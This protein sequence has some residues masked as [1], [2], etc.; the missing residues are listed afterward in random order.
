MMKLL[1]K[2]GNMIDT[3]HG[4]TM[5][6]NTDILIYDGKIQAIG[7]ISDQ[8]DRTIELSG[9]YVLPGLINAHV[10]LFGE[11]KPAKA[12]SGGALQ[13]FLMLILKTPLGAK[14]MDKIIAANVQTQLKSG[15]TT[16]RAVG[17]FCH[18]DIRV[19]DKIKAGKLCASY[20]CVRNSPSPSPADT[21][22]AHLRGQPPIFRHFYPL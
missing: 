8:A 6:R 14:I 4:G 21:V 7:K 18:S 22:T 15:V 12:L 9:A 20:A 17:D 13:K 11:G 2:N 5:R 3:E 16:I 10:H 1:L 19:R